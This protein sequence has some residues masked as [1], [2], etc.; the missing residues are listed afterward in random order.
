MALRVHGWRA[1]AAEAGALD[2]RPGRAMQTLSGQFAPPW[3]LHGADKQHRA[4]KSAR[5]WNW[6]YEVLRRIHPWYSARLPE[7]PAAPHP[8]HQ[9]SAEQLQ[10]GIEALD[11]LVASVICPRCGG[12]I[13]QYSDHVE[14]TCTC[15]QAKPAQES[16]RCRRQGSGAWPEEAGNETTPQA[17]RRTGW[18]PLAS[19]RFK[20][21][22]AGKC[23]N[24]ISTPPGCMSLPGWYW[25][26]L[27]GLLSGVPSRWRAA[28]REA[29][30]QPKSTQ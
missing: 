5:S 4:R 26:V 10:R 24:V 12:E 11:G 23:T 13:R 21:R 14:G 22:F 15:G 19:R 3:K 1:S 20:T 27:R 8:A 6:F 29:Q 9:A 16:P 17:F 28:R 25:H 18:P 2:R 7:A 30:E